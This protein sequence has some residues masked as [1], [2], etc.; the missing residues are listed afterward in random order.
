MADFAAIKRFC[1]WFND[2]T[3]GGAIHK[4]YAEM[5]RAFVDPKYDPQQDRLKELLDYATA[6]CPFYSPFRGKALCEFPIVNKN[7]L[8]ANDAEIAVDPAL[9]PFQDGR[10]VHVQK[11]SGSTGTPFAVR[12]DFR[13]RQR[14]VASLKFFGLHAGFK[15]HERLVQC[16]IW[17]KWQSKSTGQIFRE[18]ITPFNIDK[19]SEDRARELC[20]T[21]ASQHARAVLAYGSWM[22]VFADYVKRNSVCFDKLRVIITG[23]EPL[24][25]KARE[26]LKETLKCRVVER[27]ADEEMGV[28]GQQ[29]SEDPSNAYYLDRSSYVFEILKLDSDEPA[30]FGEL[31]RIVVTDLY[32]YAFPMIRY[33][34]GDVGVMEAGNEFSHGSPYLAKLYGRRLDMVYDADGNPVAPMV[35]ARVLKNLPGIRQWQF[36]QKDANKYLVRLNVSGKVDEAECVK[37]L[38]EYFGASADVGFEY[39][40]EI[41]VLASGKRK[42]VICEYK[43]S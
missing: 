38:R 6:N 35:L 14:R 5:K 42:A 20:E 34:T 18:N 37:A 22:D 19:M 31:G 30:P 27:Y 33:D 9:I 41:P 36:V 1:F 4:A 28:F 25:E 23:S 7:V 11:T 24:N 43:K 10:P 26:T 15:S 39:L 3:R 12:Q 40:D 21:I 16:R 13:K 8:I 2:W 29:V 32:N 17:T